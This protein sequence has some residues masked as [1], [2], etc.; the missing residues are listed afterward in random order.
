MQA[1][2]SAISENIKEGGDARRVFHGRGHQYPGLEW[3]TVDWFEPVVWV[4]L[5]KEPPNGWIDAFRGEINGLSMP[6]VESVLL[7][8]RYLN[9]PQV[10]CLR[11]NPVY[12]VVARENGLCYQVQFG[13]N[14]NIGFFLDMRNVREW[15]RTQANGLRVLNLFAYTCAFSVAARAGGALGVVNLDMAKSSLATGRR[16]HELNHLDVRDIGFLPHNLFKSWG[17]LRKTGPYDLVIIDP[18]TFQQGSFDAVKD[19]SKIIARLPDLLTESGQVLACLNSPDLT[20]DY[21]KGLFP[22]DLFEVEGEL[23]AA[24][25]FIESEKDKGLKVVV[26][27]KIGALPE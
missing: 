23:A 25:E 5:Y 7:Q 21:L 13:R 26:M 15:V 9:Q 18:P 24:P 20:S 12:A 2:I 3:V 17:K 19:Y 27:R 14:Q 1:L 4:V 6:G 16:N 11:G 22:A 10:E 8:F